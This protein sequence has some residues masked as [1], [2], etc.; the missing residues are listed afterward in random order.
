MTERSQHCR[1]ECFLGGPGDQHREFGT[2]GQAGERALVWGLV[3]VRG[4]VQGYD[5]MKRVRISSEV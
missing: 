3:C 1:G 2:G 5:V 4:E